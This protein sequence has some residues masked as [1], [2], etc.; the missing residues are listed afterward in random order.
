[1]Q[2]QTSFLATQLAAALTL[3]TYDVLVS[4]WPGKML[5]GSNNA[6]SLPACFGPVTELA[7]TV[8]SHQYS[9]DS[10]SGGSSSST[11]LEGSL[12]ACPLDVARSAVTVLQHLSTRIH[13]DYSDGNPMGVLGAV[14]LPRNATDAWY[15]LQLLLL[16]WAIMAWR[17]RHEEQQSQQLQQGLQ[18]QQQV[19][20]GH[21]L[22]LSQWGLQQAWL[23][24]TAEDAGTKSLKHT[25]D[26]VSTAYG[27]CGLHR[28]LHGFQRLLAGSSSSSS[29]DGMPS[30]T[31]LLLTLL[32]ATLLSSDDITKLLHGTSKLHVVYKQ[33]VGA[34]A[35][36]EKEVALAAANLIEPV[37]LQLAPAA[38]AAAAASTAAAVGAAP[39]PAAG[40]CQAGDHLFGSLSELVGLMADQAGACILPESVTTCHMR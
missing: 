12:E 35:G 15:K 9:G 31:P 25:C 28:A 5:A 2:Q 4:C 13:A 3:S 38:Q 34:R 22:L 20:R 27:A 1:V 6:R 39:Q 40:F 21:R 23:A 10:S 16:C 36:R 11:V 14:E 19:V 33:M 18:Q 8:L 17:K 26:A 7:W 30:A 24:P 37:L 29:S 32:E